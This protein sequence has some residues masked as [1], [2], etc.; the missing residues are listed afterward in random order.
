MNK[1]FPVLL[2]PVNLN[3]WSC[4]LLL[5]T[6]ILFSHIS[7]A[8]I[9]VPETY[10][11]NKAD[12]QPVQ[13]AEPL[14][15]YQVVSQEEMD[16]W[17][18]DRSHSGEKLWA[19]M[20]WGG[21][22]PETKHLFDYNI[23]PNRVVFSVKD[24]GD[25]VR[26]KAIWRR[27]ALSIRL[28][29][30]KLLSAETDEEITD[31]RI[32]HYDQ[33]KV[34]V[35]F[36]PVCGP[37]IYYLYYGALEQPLF[38]P[39]ETWLEKAEAPAN[40]INAK[41]ERI[42][43]RC[44]LDSFYPMETIALKAEVSKLLSMFPGAPYL[45]FP[46]DR[47]NSIKMQHE[48]PAC[49]AFRDPQKEFVLE[50][51]RNEYRVFQ[52]GI[53]A[54]R[55]GLRD[56]TVEFSDFKSTAGNSRLP[57]DW[58]QCLTLTSNI[59]S[60]YIQKPSGLY[61]VPKNQVRALWCGIDLPEDVSQGE[62]HGTVVVKPQGQSPS[63]IPV[64]LNISNKIVAE[65]GDHDLWR[66]SRLRWIESNIGLSE[67]IFPPF[68]PLKFSK[69]GRTISTWGHTLVLNKTGMPE[70][71]LFG[72]EEIIATPITL[73]VSSGG[74]EQTWDKFDCTFTDVTDTHVIWLG[75]AESA[76]LTLL[77]EGRMDFDGCIIMTMKLEADNKC[78]VDD[79]K[80]DIAWSKKHA[81]LAAGMGYRGKRTRDSLWRSIPR[82][83]GFFGPSL[84]L[85]SMEAG[86]G[87]ITWSIAQWEDAA[88]MDAAM[89]TEQGD[90]VL[91]QLNLGSHEISPNHS[92]QMQFAL[93]PTPVKPADL[94]HWQFRY[95]H[96]GGGFVA[97][98]DDTPQSYLK[99]NCKR[100]NELVDLGVK[101]LNLHDWWGP[102]F[103]YAWQW[104][105]PDNLSRLTKEAHKR[106]IF[107]KVYNSGRELS[108]LAPEFWA[109][110][111]EGTR[112]KF[113]N[114]IKPEPIGNFQDAWHENHLLDGLPQGWPRLHK[115]FGNEHS[116]PV[117]N[118][119]RNGNFYLESIRYMT[120]NF[121]TDGAYWDGADGPTLGHREM[122]RRLW[123]ILRKT[124]PDATIDAHHGNSLLNSPIVS[125]ML[126]LPFIDSIWHGEGYTYDWLDPWAWLV[127][128]SGLPFGIPSEMLTG[129][130]YLDRGM[131]FGIWPRMGWS[132]GTEKQRKLWAFFDQFN[133]EN[134]IM[135]GWWE[136]DNGVTVDRPD[137]YATAYSHPSN[138]VLLAVAS[139]H[140]PLQH[141][142]GSSIDVSLK[143][144][145]TAFKLPEGKLRATDIMS[146]EE[147][148]IFKPVTLY[149]P[150]N[151]KEWYANTVTSFEGRLIWVRG[152]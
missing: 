125:Y 47:D 104:E 71:I 108:T 118:S 145:R 80:F 84:W 82:E 152:E 11:V 76:Q 66:L 70:K 142:V 93:R 83:L 110:V 137:I 148:D 36:N 90:K 58:F 109:L 116:V 77:I 72:D 69:S 122:A 121:G 42:E 135:R 18:L 73:N 127:E 78:N 9:I 46:Q 25:V 143:L 129:E 21:H 37:G 4:V 132:A 26:G 106:G 10:L 29:G 1:I 144:D 102:S 65:R 23:W 20:A 41:T 38:N 140:P 34:I 74:S 101:R 114:E 30:L 107:V 96:R 105:G 141:W 39:S 134:A 60:I 147:L 54:C 136:W 139:W 5:A 103:N 13:P 2:V 53:W 55:E 128:I 44:R 24:E 16:A 51:D 88:R 43:A 126:V 12:L 124:N 28:K 33:E 8:Q 97:S 95:L 17:P 62:Y 15:D 67:E 52:I 99:D 56:I 3:G 48:I 6:A 131:L 7:Y 57:S 50:T 89:V 31:A 149:W 27:S 91:M 151:V 19:E 113:R 64:C 79:L 59:K 115:D 130:L 35:D 81:E 87:W 112:Y 92:W 119:T 68:E 117:S 94:R 150:K 32:V 85:G 111:Y 61:P 22:D 138:G 123:T 133:I 40:L 100:L 75:K 14:L 45:I 49:W 63:K 146:G 86:L 120:E 98:D